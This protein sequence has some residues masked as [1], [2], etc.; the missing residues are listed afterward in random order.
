MTT[1]PTVGTV[2]LD[3]WASWCGP[4][5]MLSPILD[6]IAN[7]KKITLIKIDVEAEPKLAQEYNVTSLPTVIIFKDGKIVANLTGSRPKTE[8]IK[9]L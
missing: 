5:I 4:C 8:Y 2:M 1:I 6:E 7:E 3:F 9:M